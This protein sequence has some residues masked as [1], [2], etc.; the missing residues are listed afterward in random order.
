MTRILVYRPFI[1]PPKA[2]NHSLEEQI[3]SQFPFPAVSICNDAAKSCA[4]FIED[5][6]YAGLSDIPYMI[7][8]AHVSA[9]VL[10]AGIWALKAKE[11]TQAGVPSEDIKP[12][13][14]QTV[15]SLMGNALVLLR[16]LEHAAPRWMTASYYL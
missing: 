13:I 15:D 14:A 1:P 2:A 11:K 12:P 9:A 6:M 5:Q 4:K 16:V 7:A 8:G 3:S 10:L